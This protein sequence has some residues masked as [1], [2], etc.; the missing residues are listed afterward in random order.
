MNSSPKELEPFV[1][2]FK[3]QSK[4]RDEE[5]WMM[6]IYTMSAFKTVID[7]C[8]NGRKA[9]T[10]Y[11]KEPLTKTDKKSFD[12]MTEEEKKQARESERIKAISFLSRYKKTEDR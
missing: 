5:M 8:I 3:M 4:R 9:K 7:Q 2:A 11:I 10:E 12:E 6:G 1:E